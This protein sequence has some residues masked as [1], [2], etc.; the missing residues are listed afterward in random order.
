MRAALVSGEDGLVD[1]AL[2]VVLHLLPLVKGRVRVTVRVTV[3]LR[4]RVRATLTLGLPEAQP[5]C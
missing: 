4:V 1:G 5:S 3:T 2:E